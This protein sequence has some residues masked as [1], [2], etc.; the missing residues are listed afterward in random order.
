MRINGG[1]IILICSLIFII[2]GCSIFKNPSLS[3]Y[4]DRAELAAYAE[5]YNA[6]QSDF[7][8]LITFHPAPA[9]ALNKKKD[10][11]DI[12]IGTGLSDPALLSLLEPLNKL[13]RDDRLSHDA[14]YKEMLKLGLIEETQHLLPLNFSLP[15]IIFKPRA[16]KEDLPPMM[17]SLDNL[18]RLASDFNEE[19][20]EYFQKMG[21]SPLWNEKFIYY[22]ANLFGTD[23][24]VVDGSVLTWNS[25]A[26]DRAME[27]CRNWLEEACGGY[28]KEREFTEKYINAPEYR[29]LEDERI[30][31]YMSDIRSFL[32]IPEQKRENLEFRWL[33]HENR[34]P[35]EEDILFAGI[36]RGAKN[37]KGAR[38]FL[39]WIFK[40]ENQVKFLETNY[41]KRLQGVFGIANGFSALTDVNERDLPKPQYN[42]LF[43][44]NIPAPDHL[45]FPSALPKDWETKKSDLV[46]P[47]MY[48]SVISAKTEE[49]LNDALKDG[50]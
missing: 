30:L 13:F 46:I 11:P 44:G 35:V 12:L 38:A 37:K 34:I 21:F 41:Y 48:R 1:R 49:N 4:T 47:W 2:P 5:V 31:F 15:A 42:P 43:I 28:V 25:E 24:K 45:L 17:I 3:L 40:A 39:E 20:D 6:V 50:E 29:L 10:N 7:R 18:K 22:V 16:V 19:K 33:S 27:Y 8:L 26:L 9:E 14:F 32:Q 36:P 23:F